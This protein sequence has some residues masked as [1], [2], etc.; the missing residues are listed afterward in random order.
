MLRKIHAVWLA[1]IVVVG[2]SG[3]AVP[4]VASAAPAVSSENGFAASAYGTQVNVGSIVK[5]G[6]SALATLGCTATAGI[7]HTNT[8]VSVTAAPVLTSGTVDTSAAS[9][10]TAGG[11]AST[12]SSDIQSVS[13]LAGLVSASAVKS[14]STASQVSLTGAFGVSAAGTQFV[15]LEV[16]GH[17]ISGTPAPNTKIAL[18]GVGYVVLNQQVKQLSKTSASLTVIAIH[19]YVTGVVTGVAKGTQAV[20]AFA[21]SKIGG[22]VIGLLSGQ[23]YGAD[24]N[25]AKTII[26]GTLFPQSLACFGTDG[27]TET[28]SGASVTIPGILTSGTVTDTAEGIETSTKLSGTVTSTVQGLNLLSGTVAATAIKA[29]VSA[30]GNPP[31]LGDRSS[32]VGLSVAGHPAIG[33]KVAANTKLSLAGIGTLWLHRVLRTSRGITVIMVQLDVTVAGNPFGLK[34]GTVVNVG[35][36]RISVS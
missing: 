33:D 12:A 25:V 24:A 36:A 20:V 16:A 21:T 11:D 8:A 26:A 18:P 30:S 31:K 10:V 35:Y 15:G 28:N 13:I 3:L 29:D 23:A 34:T 14:V 1:A 6:R 19:L 27:K 7:T 5:S 32:F 17:S 2:G 22:P 9:R 4:S